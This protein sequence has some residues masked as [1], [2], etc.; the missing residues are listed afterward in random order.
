MFD[1]I[2]CPKCRKKLA[3]DLQGTLIVS[4]PRCKEVHK[5]DSRVKVHPKWMDLPP[6]RSVVL[7]D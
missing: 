2:R 7:E 4:C 1:K 6:E 3:E 5:F